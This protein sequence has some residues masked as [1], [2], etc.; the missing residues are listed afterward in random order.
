[1]YLETARLV[2]YPMTLKQIKKAIWHMQDVIAVYN[3]NMKSLGFWE[4][5][6]KRLVYII[7]IIWLKRIPSAWP[8]ATMWLIVYKKEC[9]LVGEIGFKKPPGTKKTIE[10][11]Y[12]T[13]ANDRGQGYM[14]E[15][16]EQLIQYA[17]TQ[18]TYDV[19]TI[20]ALTLPKNIA[21]QRVL[22]KN[23]FNKVPKFSRYICWKRNP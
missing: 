4:M 15:A 10:I 22:M 11:G 1:M 19:R 12:N 14:T 18:D 9:R 7:K 21:S 8:L 5:M 6:Q 20:T 13:C 2:L 3:A 17:F 16:V 23:H